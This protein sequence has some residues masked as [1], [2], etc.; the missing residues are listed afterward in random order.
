M[1]EITPLLLCLQVVLAKTTLHQL[2]HVVFAMLCNPDSLPF[3]II[4]IRGCD[5]I[6]VKCK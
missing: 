3:I 5:T 2:E 4:P 1:S 6:I